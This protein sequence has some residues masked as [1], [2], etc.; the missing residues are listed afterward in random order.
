MS[1]PKLVF[2]SKDYVGGN[3]LKEEYFTNLS[4]NCLIE[5]IMSRYNIN[6]HEMKL[7]VQKYTGH[8][9]YPDVKDSKIVQAYMRINYPK[10]VTVN[11]IL[12]I[13]K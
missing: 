1:T 12:K 13:L 9:V 3:I 2:S 8:P 10:F 6:I 5:R 11:E 4:Q 7:A